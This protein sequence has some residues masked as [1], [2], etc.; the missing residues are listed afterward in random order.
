MSDLDPRLQS[1]LAAVEASPDDLDLWDA[2]ED[3]A[4]KL[5]KPDEVGQLYR[6]VLA[7]NLT[8]SQVAA[9][10][11]V[12]PSAIGRSASSVSEIARRRRS[13][14]SWRPR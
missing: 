12:P 4:A 9:Q 7:R 1:A 3:V 2:L 11:A 8:A 13:A 5:Q 10:D 14:R 6:D